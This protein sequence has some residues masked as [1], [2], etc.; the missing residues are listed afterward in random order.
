M[1]LLRNQMALADLVTK[2]II[3]KAPAY[4]E[5]KLIYSESTD[6]DVEYMLCSNKATLALPGQPRVH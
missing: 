5:T 4:A 3:G 2:G 1:S 6:K